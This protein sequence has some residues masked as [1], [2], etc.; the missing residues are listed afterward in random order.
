MS[1]RAAGSSR[2]PSAR[3][4]PANRRGFAS[5]AP[6]T[7]RTTQRRVRRTLR[8]RDEVHSRG[9]RSL[10]A[11]RAPAVPV[12]D[13]AQRPL[14]QFLHAAGAT[15]S[16]S[17]YPRRPGARQARPRRRDGPPTEGGSPRDPGGFPKRN[18]Q[19]T[20]IA[21]LPEDAPE[22]A[23][24]RLFDE[25]RTTRERS[26]MRARPARRGLRGRSARRRVAATA[27]VVHRGV[28]AQPQGASQDRRASLA[29]VATSPRTLRVV[30]RPPYLLPRRLV[31]GSCWFRRRPGRSLD[32]APISTA[33][34]RTPERSTMCY[35]IRD[36]RSAACLD[37]RVA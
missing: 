36:S 8:H 16:V 7:R 4:R 6:T 24:S 30:E 17:L 29:E 25:Y 21:G 31:L 37:R 34:G 3:L 1:A 15:R 11:V 26:A 5:P 23:L 18:I 13:A 22:L 19:R 20:E 33:G 28:R 32:G 27:A 2:R 9:P 14:E 10:G 35:S 12:R